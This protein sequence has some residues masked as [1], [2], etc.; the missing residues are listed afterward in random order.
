MEPT[1]S[2]GAANHDETVTPRP[3]GQLPVRFEP[4][5]D[6]LEALEALEAMTAESDDAREGVDEFLA[7]G[8]EEAGYGYGV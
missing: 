7:P 5:A 6:A 1:D 8:L 3:A 2:T 4:A